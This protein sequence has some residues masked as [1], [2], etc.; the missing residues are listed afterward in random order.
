MKNIN[1]ENESKNKKENNYDTFQ[2]PA[3]KNEKYISILNKLKHK[4]III[5]FIFSFIR[6]NP[7]PIFILIEK[8]KKLKND[9]NYCFISTKKKIIYQML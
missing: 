3:Q 8:D 2:S 5:E 4:P 1:N 7:L 6:K 9:I